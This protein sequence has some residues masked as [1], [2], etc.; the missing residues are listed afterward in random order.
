MCQND[1]LNFVAE[2]ENPLAEEEE[3]VDDQNVGKKQLKAWKVYLILYYV[4]IHIFE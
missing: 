4:Y 2:N 1:V 3:E